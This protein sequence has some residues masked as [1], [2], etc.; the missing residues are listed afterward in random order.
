MADG[1]G[2]ADQATRTLERLGAL[3]G[4]HMHVQ[5]V[6]EQV[7]AMCTWMRDNNITAEQLSD[8]FAS[9]T[10]PASIRVTGPEVL[11]R[12]LSAMHAELWSS[13]R[14]A[15]MRLVPDLLDLATA[16]YQISQWVTYPFRTAAAG[17]ADAPWGPGMGGGAAWDAGSRAT[18]LR[19]QSLR[20]RLVTQPDI[21][22]PRVDALAGWLTHHGI[23]IAELAEQITSLTYVPPSPTDPD[24]ELPGIGVEGPHQLFMALCA[25]YME[26]WPA[27]DEQH[28][29]RRI[30]AQMHYWLGPQVLYDWLQCFPITPES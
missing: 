2:A 1:A 11:L 30:Q 29:L 6:R 23:L 17:G 24:S 28:N 21:S 5:P 26:D 18:S 27:R 12:W 10:R 8:E 13:A 25:L 7:V 3:P 4:R 14:Y 9:R 22:Y 15:D 19:H 20:V 16:L